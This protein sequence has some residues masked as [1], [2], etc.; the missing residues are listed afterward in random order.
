MLTVSKENQK[1]RSKTT[2]KLDLSQK[3]R[4]VTPTRFTP[5]IYLLTSKE[6]RILRKTP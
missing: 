1:R 4:K 2:A 6:A 5:L 3:D